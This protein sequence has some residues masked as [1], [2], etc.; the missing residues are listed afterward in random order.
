MANI[1]RIIVLFILSS[2]YSRFCRQNYTNTHFSSMGNIFP[3]TSKYFWRYKNHP[4]WQ[5]NFYCFNQKTCI[6]IYFSERILAYY[7][8]NEYF[9]SA[10]QVMPLAEQPKGREGIGRKSRTVPATVDALLQ[11]CAKES[12]CQKKQVWWEGAHFRAKSGNLPENAE[13]LKR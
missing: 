10:F 8:N 6:L 7:T 3:S 12:H 9:C 4:L 5:L 11:K 1:D 2:F 13:T